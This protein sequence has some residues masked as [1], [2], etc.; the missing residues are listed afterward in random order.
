MPITECSD[1]GSNSSRAS[2][3]N[4]RNSVNVCECFFL[5]LSDLINV[6]K[7]TVRHQADYS[8]WS[9]ATH[10][11]ISW[12]LSLSLPEHAYG[13]MCTAYSIHMVHTQT[14][15][16]LI[17][18]SRSIRVFAYVKLLCI[19]VLIAAVV[20][21]FMSPFQHVILQQILFFR[22]LA[23]ARSLTQ[24]RVRSQSLVL[25]AYFN[26]VREAGQKYFAP[27]TQNIIIKSL[28]QLKDCA[29]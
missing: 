17:F 6:H 13:I 10:F 14:L 16:C 11:D 28:A 7:Y 1:S 27:K 20:I 23:L 21:Y 24:L 8:S 3:E 25:C 26:Y 9:K 29:K 18:S 12:A 22:A 19:C 4:A 15:S 2:S 5:L